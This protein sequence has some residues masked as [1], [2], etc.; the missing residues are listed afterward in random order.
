VLFVALSGVAL[1]GIGSA[2]TKLAVERRAAG[3]I[4]QCHGARAGLGLSRRWPAKAP[5]STFFVRFV[6]SWFA[7]DHERQREDG[8][9]G[10]GAAHQFDIEITS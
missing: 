3:N 2:N 5:R 10:K 9:E 6:S 4:G 8:R 1:R 7:S